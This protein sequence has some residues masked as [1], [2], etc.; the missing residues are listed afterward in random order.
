MWGFA[1]AASSKH[2][3][4]RVGP[5]IVA[6]ALVAT[7]CGGGGSNGSPTGPTDG[8]GTGT[9]GDPQ[10]TITITSDGV[11]P[12]EVTIAPGTRVRFVNN[13]RIA[14]D[15]NSDPHPEHTDCPAINQVGFIQPNQ[16]KDTGPLTA[17]R[18]CGFHDHNQPSNDSL[19]GRII[20][21]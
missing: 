2:G 14:H 1:M 17:V 7:A 9:P 21:R 10:A 20:V 4:V 16:T 6:A 15:I 18:T 8:G 3:G 5:Y 12:R 13:N 19:T 11:S